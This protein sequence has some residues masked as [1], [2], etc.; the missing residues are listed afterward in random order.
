MQYMLSLL[1]KKRHY[2]SFSR[3]FIYSNSFL[4]G[5]KTNRF[6]LF[7]LVFKSHW[8]WRSMWC[9][10]GW[11]LPNLVK[12]RACAD[13]CTDHSRTGLNQTDYLD[14]RR[15]LLLVSR[16]TYIPSHPPLHSPRWAI[17][18]ML[19]G[20]YPPNTARLFLLHFIFS[21]TIDNFDKIIL[22]FFHFLY[23]VLIWKHPW[24]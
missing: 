1:G 15:W 3:K 9:G 10:C 11:N 14:S 22:V 4:V 21:I 20:I 5:M 13:H 12:W 18:P 24:I 8:L 6:E 16:V 2:L 19:H 17:T 7:I 23:H